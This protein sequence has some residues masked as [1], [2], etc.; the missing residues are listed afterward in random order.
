V[1]PGHWEEELRRSVDTNLRI[2]F[3]DK[4]GKFGIWEVKP[5]GSWEF[6][7]WV[8]TKDGGFRKLDHEVIREAIS[9]DARHRENGL[10]S[11][12]DDIHQEN[13]RLQAEKKA[14]GQRIMYDVRKDA[15][16]DLLRMGRNRVVFRPGKG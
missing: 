6:I 1:R 15:K 10:V 5:W 7:R 14:R 16:R 4:E 13:D 12:I 3:S 11:V 8:Q 2:R 9:L